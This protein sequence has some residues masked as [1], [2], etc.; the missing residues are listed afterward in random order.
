MVFDQ[1]LAKNFSLLTIII[2]AY[3]SQCYFVD[4]SGWVLFQLQDQYTLKML[5]SYHC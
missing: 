5:S 2:L 3:L 1:L 4:N